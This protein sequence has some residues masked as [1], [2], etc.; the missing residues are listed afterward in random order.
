[1][2]S[3]H[4][5]PTCCC[6]TA[7]TIIICFHCFCFFRIFSYHSQLPESVQQAAPYTSTL[8]QTHIAATVAAIACLQVVWGIHRP[9]A[10]YHYEASFI[11]FMHNSFCYVSFIGIFLISLSFYIS[12]ESFGLEPHRK[13]ESYLKSHLLSHVLPVLI[14]PIKSHDVVCHYRFKCVRSSPFNAEIKR[15]KPNKIQEKQFLGKKKL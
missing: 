11:I 13:R 3:P 1:M 14:P 5:R 6:Y 8:K 7:I 4:Q 2:I 10:Q 9:A 15:K 12:V